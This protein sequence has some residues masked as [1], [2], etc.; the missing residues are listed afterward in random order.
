MTWVMHTTIS[1]KQ[2]SVDQFRSLNGITSLVFQ[3]T[4]RCMLNA[5]MIVIGSSTYAHCT[6]HITTKPVDRHTDVCDTYLKLNDWGI[7]KCNDSTR[8]NY[9]KQTSLIRLACATTCT[10][11]AKPISTPTVAHLRNSLSPS[12]GEY[13]RYPTIAWPSKWWK[14]ATTGH[15][16][17]AALPFATQHTGGLNA[18]WLTTCKCQ[19]PNTRMCWIL[20]LS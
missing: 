13:S 15:H 7:D 8:P 4:W 18:D 12:N 3:I 10:R 17:N 2:Y 5:L 14:Q 19:L 20:T 6:C 11:S 9:A 1:T 16:S